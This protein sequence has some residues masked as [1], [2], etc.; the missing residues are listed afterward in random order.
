MG[1]VTL[2]WAG[3]Q[4]DRMEATRGLPCSQDTSSGAPCTS[5]TATGVVVR[6]ATAY[7]EA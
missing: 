3:I 4:T 5:T 6:L 2:T 7:R 1:V